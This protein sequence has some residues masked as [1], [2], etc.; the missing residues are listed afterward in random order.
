MGV[1]FS[2]CFT[3]SDARNVPAIQAERGW[4][5]CRKHFTALRAAQ[6]A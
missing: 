1:L 5:D 4:A 3:Q 2:K 6:L